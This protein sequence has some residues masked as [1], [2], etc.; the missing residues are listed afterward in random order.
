VTA[1]RRSFFAWPRELR[2][3][4]IL[5]INAR[6]AGYTLKWNERRLYPNVDDKLRTKAL[7]EAAGVPVPAT[8]AVAYT[9]HDVRGLVEAL[10]P[11][12]SFV[13]KPAHG[14]M[15]SGILV[16]VAREGH[17]LQRPSGRWI[18]VEDFA[19]HAS[20]ILSGLYALGG[21][22]DVAFVEERLEVHPDL[23]AISVEGVPDVRIVVYRGVPVMAM[24]RLPTRRSGGRAN[25]H[26][27]AIGAGIDLETG[28]ITHAVH[29][30]V[31]VERH[32]DSESVIVGV[33]VPQ[34]SELLRAALLAVD[35]AGLG[36][37]G[38]DMVVD[39][40]RG[41]VLLEMNARPGLAIQLANGA[42]LRHRLGAVDQHVEPDMPL[43]ERLALGQ[44]IAAGELR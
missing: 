26:Q 11:Y 27:G 32:P 19:Y 24:T 31:P 8:L 4:G 7:C 38:A 9:Q 41:P 23:G 5:G 42:G 3:A 10:E 28:E 39:A 6:N 16:L 17:R 36:Y 18:G 2:A 1:Q 37:V 43:G 14:A 44:R 33:R 13:L 21:Q 15:G 34:W 35:H 40:S 12:A 30:G 22:P 25:L 29:G 20:S